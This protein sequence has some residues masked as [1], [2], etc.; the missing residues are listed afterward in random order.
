M[1][2]GAAAE[3]VVRVLERDGGLQVV[4]VKLSAISVPSKQHDQQFWFDCTSNNV[5]LN[6]KLFINTDQL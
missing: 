6:Y 5:Q 2:A 4:E 1:G 3:V